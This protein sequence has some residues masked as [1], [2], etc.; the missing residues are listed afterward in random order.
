MYSHSHLELKTH[1]LWAHR[2][3]TLAPDQ[4]HCSYFSKSNGVVMSDGNPVVIY[5]RMKNLSAIPCGEYGF[6]TGVQIFIHQDS[7][8]DFQSAF[9]Q[10][11]NIRGQT[12]KG[13]DHSHTNFATADVYFD[14]FIS[15]NA[16]TV[17]PGVIHHLNAQ[18]RL[19]GR[20]LHR[21]TFR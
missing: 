1:F 14:G 9:G 12:E 16:D 17:D 4:I 2:V 15:K 13:A 11:S 8:V 7:S 5:F 10:K 18:S 3:L 6:K 21:V 19:N 20:Q